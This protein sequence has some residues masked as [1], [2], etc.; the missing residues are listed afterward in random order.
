MRT[1]SK[2][3]LS[4]FLMLCLSLSLLAFAPARGEAADGW[5]IQ[6]V[7]IQTNYTPVALMDPATL[8]VETTTE[9]CSVSGTAWYASGGGQI[10]DRFGTD[11]VYLEVELSTV[12]G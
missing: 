5:P 4:L 10:S 11:P 7:R 12:G 1:T 9:N 6:A 2:R 3:L 8:T